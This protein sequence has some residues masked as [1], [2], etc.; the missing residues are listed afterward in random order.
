MGIIDLA[1]R[2]LHLDT[3]WRS[4]IRF[5]NQSFDVSDRTSDVHWLKA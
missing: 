2:I 3:R 5:M 4:V 1:P